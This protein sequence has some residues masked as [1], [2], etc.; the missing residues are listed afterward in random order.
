MNG[1]PGGAPTGGPSGGPR[2]G[3]VGD[4][5]GGPNGGPSG[6]P[7]SGMIGD[8]G[9]GPN[10]GPTGGPGDGLRRGTSGRRAT[11]PDGVIRALAARQH[12]VVGRAQLLQAELPVHVIDF[13]VK[14]GVLHRL[15]R[16]VYRVGPVPAPYEREMAAVLACGETAVVSHRTAAA[17]WKLLPDR[18]VDARVEVSIRSGCRNPGSAVLAHRVPGLSADETTFID[19]VP[20][21]VPARTV[22]D[23]AVSAGEKEL[24]QALA[25]ADRQGLAKRGQIVKL[26]ARYPRRAGTLNLRALL[27]RDGGPALTRS[28]AESRFLTLVRTAQLGRPEAN[29]FVQGSEVDFLWRAE[30]VVVEVD[31]RA[32]HSSSGAFERDRRRDALFAAAGF[33]VIRVTW[34]QLSMEPE[35]LLVRLARALATRSVV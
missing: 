11:D 29:A 32:F 27:A 25:Q 8:P 9:C 10:G 14:K 15:H 7:R 33:L 28:E 16:G 20:V 18:G 21:T 35:A 19:N 30:R 13:R 34:R 31:G 26:L 22:L 6:G 2:S 3:M 4:P 12:G 1:D 24:E 23:L 5:G 17:L